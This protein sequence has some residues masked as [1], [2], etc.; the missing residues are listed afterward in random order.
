MN[1]WIIYQKERFPLLAHGPLILV[2]SFSAVSFSALLRDAPGWP[3]TQ[4]I[5]TAFV[6]C[7]IS[8]LHLRIADEFKDFEEDS[9]YRPYRAVPRGLVTL[10]ELSWVWAGTAVIQ[11]ILAALLDWRLAGVLLVTWIYLALM[12]KEFFVRE[13][14]VKRPFTYLWTHMLIMP[15]IDL[16]A[17]AA[18]WAPTEG[19]PPT[20]IVLFVIVSFFNGVVIEIGRKIRAPEAEEEGVPT[21]TVT[22]GMRGAVLA[23]LTALVLTIGTGLVAASLIDFTLP[24]AIIWGAFLAAGI[25]LA[26]SFLRQPTVAGGKRFETLAGL[27]T[28]ALYL[29]LGL[30]PRFF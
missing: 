10:R 20:G 6:C 19:R 17:T 23:W 22:W 25:G 30:L 11:L 15:L 29:T 27:W 9:R 26:L 8:F 28:I 4:A 14:L 1:R 16:F 7:L 13:W 21:Y 24:A 18:D 3:S 5:V 2:F 12:S